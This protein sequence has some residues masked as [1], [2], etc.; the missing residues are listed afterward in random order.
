MDAHFLEMCTTTEASTATT[1]IIFSKM[2]QVV[3]SC[4]VPWINF[5]GVGIEN[6]NVKLGKH[7]SI[8]RRVQQAN[9][10]IYFMG[11]TCHI[12]HIANIAADSPTSKSSSACQ[13]GGSAF[14]QLWNGLSNSM[15]VCTPT[16][17]QRKN[18]NPG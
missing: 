8:K 2:N 15:M 13:Q 16:F 6:T 11:C 3:L 14:H 7:T 12:A 4:E 5:L 9:P 1:E 18:H 10:A 17:S